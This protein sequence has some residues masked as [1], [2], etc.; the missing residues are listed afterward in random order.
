MQSARAAARC[1]SS[2]ASP[3]AIRRVG[4]VGLGLMGHGILQAAAAANFQVVG[5]DN[6]DAAVSR[7]MAMV[8]KS[9]DQIAA[10]AVKSGASAEAAAAES[11]RVLTNISVSTARASL[12]DVDLIIEAVPE[13]MAIKTPLY[14]ELGLIARPDAILASNTSGLPVKALADITGRTA[15]T[16]GLHYFNPV[17]VI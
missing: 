5:V 12:H 7:G 13:T 11:A 14:K 2:S 16:I 17:Q 15:T 8:K 1:F 3:A 10:R 4:V 6:D 9:L